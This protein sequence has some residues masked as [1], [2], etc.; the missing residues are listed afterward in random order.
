MEIFREEKQANEVKQLYDVPPAPVP[1]IV[2]TRKDEEKPVEEKPSEKP[3]EKKPIE[4]QVEKA[5]EKTV[6]KRNMRPTDL[7]KLQL[8]GEK[9]YAL[10]IYDYWAH[11]NKELTIRAGEKVQVSYDCYCKKITL[12]HD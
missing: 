4:K 9:K 10:V 11:N 12:I 1:V 3:I 2:V 6:E 8:N 7:P 5:P